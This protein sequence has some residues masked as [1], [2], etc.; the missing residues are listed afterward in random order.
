MARGW[1][2]QRL[3]EEMERRGCPPSLAEDVCSEQGGLDERAQIRE[4]LDKPAY[5]RKSPLQ[6]LRSLAAKGF[7]L[8]SVRV[9]I[10]RRFG[11]ELED[12]D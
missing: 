1:S 3:L 2:R 11:A 10:E 9:E 4:L 6:A 12:L 5:A 7:D 8:D